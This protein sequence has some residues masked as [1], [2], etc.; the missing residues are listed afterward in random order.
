[1]KLV[2]SSLSWPRILLLIMSSTSLSLGSPFWSFKFMSLNSSATI[3]ILVFR[4]RKE[5]GTGPRVSS[6][7]HM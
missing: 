4:V 6:I 5:E 7:S 1:M 3:S 2:T